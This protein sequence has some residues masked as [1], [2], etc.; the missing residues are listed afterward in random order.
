MT[1]RFPPAIRC[2]HCKGT[3]R[4]APEAFGQR[5]AAARTDR[6]LSYEKLSE[7]TGGLISASNINNVESDRNG[8]PRWKVVVALARAL[9][10]SLDYLSEGKLPDLPDPSE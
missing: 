8:N 5:L 7:M 2:P 4:A 9:D 1:G 6:D 10:L 3:G